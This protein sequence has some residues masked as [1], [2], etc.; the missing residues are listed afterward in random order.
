LPQ[1]Q[2]LAAEVEHVLAGQH[3]SVSFEQFFT[4]MYGND[5]ARWQAE[6]TGMP[7]YRLITNY[8]TR[9]RLV[10]EHGAMDFAHKGPLSEAPS[11]WHPWFEYAGPKFSGVNIVFGHWA[12]IDGKT[13]QPNMIALDTGCVWGRQM[14]G[15]CLETGQR[16][17]V[18]ADRG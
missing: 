11:G 10:D 5:L 9:M 4:E 3:D 17:V 16:Y 7:R 14:T 18:Q 15:L 2:Q 1:A 12:A 6:V 8:F 13:S